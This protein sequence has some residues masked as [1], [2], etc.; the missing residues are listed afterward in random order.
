MKTMLTALQTRVLG[1]LIEKERTTPDYY[2]LTLNALT[3]AC[4]Q[5]SN[6]APVME[7]TNEEVSDTLRELSLLGLARAKGGTGRSEKYVHRVDT[8]LGLDQQQ[9]A[10][11]CVLFLRGPQTLNELKTRTARMTEFADIDELQ[12][13]IEELAE[14]ANSYMEA[15]LTIKLERQAGQR[16]DRYGQLLCGPIEFEEVTRAPTAAVVSPTGERITQLEETVEILKTQIAELQAQLGVQT[17]A[18]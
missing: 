1:C 2:P 13:I 16:E 5:K 14:T 4:N 18:A 3:T 15:P 10:L 7:L 17:H 9:T 6:R 12:L 8:L 11:L